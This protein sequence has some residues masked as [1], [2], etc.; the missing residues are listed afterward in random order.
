MCA[1]VRRVSV[2]VSLCCVCKCV[3]YVQ[4][5]HTQTHTYTHNTRSLRSKDLQLSR[6]LRVFSNTGTTHTH[7]RI[8]ARTHT[9]IRGHTQVTCTLCNGAHF[10][11]NGVCPGVYVCM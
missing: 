4:Y 3:F 5:A 11:H 10:L 7:T 2:F 1:R 6:V 8:H 9:H